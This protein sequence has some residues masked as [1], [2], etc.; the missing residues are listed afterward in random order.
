M[1]Q[2]EN[3]DLQL[4]QKAVK[5]N[6]KAFTTLFNR[7]FQAVYNFA[8]TLSKDPAVAEDLT[9]EAFIRAHANLHKLGPPYNFRA[10]IFSLTRNYFIDT[11]RREKGIEQLDEDFKVVSPNLGPEKETMLTEGAER[12][13]HTLRSLPGKH[14]RLQCQSQPAPRSGGIPGELRHPALDG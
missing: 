3:P 14:Q 8:L 6:R 11:I 7:Y 10:W 9:Q 13:H 12:V 5:G 4:V 1:V 2:P